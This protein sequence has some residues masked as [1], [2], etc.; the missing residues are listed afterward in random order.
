[1]VYTSTFVFTPSDSIPWGEEKRPNKIQ[2]LITQNIYFT[3]QRSIISL[4]SINEK[5]LSDIL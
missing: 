3:R 2:A 1:M 4:S 5:C